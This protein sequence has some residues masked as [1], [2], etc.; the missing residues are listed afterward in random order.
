MIEYLRIT[1]LGVIASA[2]V[3]LA[4]GFVAVT[5][6]TGAG[7]TMVMT[8]LDLLFGGRPNA[9]LVRSGAERAQVEAGI[10]VDQD[11][12]PEALV[13]LDAVEDGLVLV[14]RSVGAA[15]SRAWLAG[16]GVPAGVLAEL[17]DELVIRH[18]QNDQRRLAHAGHRR[19]LLDR[20]AGAEVAEPLAA[21]EAA[22]DEFRA[23]QAEHDALAAADRAAAQRADLLRHGSDEI[24][25][26]A[27]EPGEDDA[28]RTELARLSNVVDLRVAAEG[29]YEAL[30]DAQEGSAEAA[31]G[32]AS[33]HLAQ[34]VRHDPALEPLQ[35]SLTTAAALVAD[36]ASDLASYAASLEA[37]PRR[38]DEAQQ[39]LAVLRGLQRK[40]G[41]TLAEVL[42]WAADAQEQL[43]LIDTAE[44]RLAALQERIAAAQHR[45]AGLA[46]ALSAARTAAARRLEEAVNAELAAL[47]LPHAAVVVAV[48]QAESSAPDGLAL[49]DGR[50][51][52]VRRDGIDEV[53]VLFA[54]HPGAPPRP[55]GEGASGGELS[56]VMLALEVALA[57]ANPVP[58]LVFDEVDA[59]IGGRAAV[60]V[61]R[62]LAALARTAQVIV[63]THLPQVA[64]FADQHVVVRK[65][66]DGQVTSSSVSSLE[67]PEQQRELARMLAGL[68][69]SDSAMAHA[70]ELIDLA[71]RERASAAEVSAVIPRAGAAGA[72]GASR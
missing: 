10:R 11:D 41:D 8:A 23:L 25:S 62:R 20:F 14:G 29:A 64:A 35:E 28:L 1:D 40:Y 69:G 72:R 6:E 7:K 44:D 39:R 15:R 46:V 58:V 19:R 38:L 27:P 51:A 5:G 4:G 65:G 3:E 37:D 61:G 45:A 54:A 30:R 13:D 67:R 50:R 71:G 43:A 12:L 49:P 68:D 22:F 18:G 47:A 70:A 17:G 21:F 16:R 59:G 2:H 26:A 42:A 63:V 53:G 66:S 56:R 31:L 32:T 55:I 34:A 57:G 9:A 48:T 36:A 33:A 24:A 60:E 52:A